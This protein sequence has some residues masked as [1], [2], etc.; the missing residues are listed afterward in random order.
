MNQRTPLW[1][2]LSRGIALCLLV[3]GLHV[4]VTAED[5]PGPPPYRPNAAKKPLDNLI[6]WKVSW[7][8]EKI[9]SRERTIR[10]KERALKLDPEKD[11]D[12]TNKEIDELKKA[13]TEDQ[14]E[15]NALTANNAFDPKMPGVNLN[16]KRLRDNVHAG[17]DYF[18][19]LGVR[20]NEE[21]SDPKKSK[22]EREKAKEKSKD[23]MKTETNLD[24]DLTKAEKDNP[25]VFK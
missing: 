20:E 23:D 14:D 10:S 21:S 7:L 5:L 2:F 13:N 18:H 1:C 12:T 6:D 25:D 8:K 16:V 15:I 4:S 24:H 22:E 3:C 11:K 17:I 9:K 19:G